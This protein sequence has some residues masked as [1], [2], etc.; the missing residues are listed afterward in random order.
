MFWSTTDGDIRWGHAQK[1]KPKQNKLE[2]AVF[3]K[4]FPTLQPSPLFCSCFFISVIALVA[5]CLSALPSFFP[6]SMSMF[7][8]EERHTVLQASLQAPVWNEADCAKASF[9]SIWAMIFRAEWE[10]RS[11]LL[12]S[13][14]A[15]GPMSGALNYSRNHH[16]FFLFRKI[17][18]GQAT[19]SVLSPANCRTS[20]GIWWHLHLWSQWCKVG[21]SLL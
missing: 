10:Q 2:T 1:H 6:L 20:W 19:V 13:F 4:A 14:V 9:H 21:L 7:L 17:T 5:L 12:L 11:W 16:S 18:L 8:N 15:A 3:L